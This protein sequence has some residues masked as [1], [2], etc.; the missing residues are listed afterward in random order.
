MELS[1]EA[2]RN[3]VRYSIKGYCM[4]CAEVQSICGRTFV[5]DADG[6]TWKVG[7]VEV[8]VAKRA[9]YFVCEN[10]DE[11]DFVVWDGLFVAEAVQGKGCR[12]AAII[13]LVA[14]GLEFPLEVMGLKFKYLQGRCPTGFLQYDGVRFMA[15]YTTAKWMASNGELLR[16]P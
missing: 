9:V 12:A 15:L 1:R 11:G 6:S 14:H 4:N 7:K 13:C 8:N 3:F 10:V 5:D 16:D 2:L